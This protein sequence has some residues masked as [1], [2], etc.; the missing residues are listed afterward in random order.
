MASNQFL[1]IYLKIVLCLMGMG[2]VGYFAYPS[3][4]AWDFSDRMDL[5]RGLVFIGFAYLLFRC[6]KELTS[7]NRPDRS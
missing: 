2:F 1:N 4:I 7:R 6:L 5:L 3:L